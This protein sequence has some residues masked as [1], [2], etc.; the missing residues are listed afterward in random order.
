MATINGLGIDLGALSKFM[1]SAYKD[2]TENSPVCHRVYNLEDAAAERLLAMDPAE[3]TETALAKF[4][5]HPSKEKSTISS[6]PQWWTDLVLKC[7]RERND[8]SSVE[9]LDPSGFDE[10]GFVI[11][12]NG[13]CTH[14]ECPLNVYYQIV[15]ECAS[16]TP[17]TQQ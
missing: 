7:V 9:I 10:K 16:T 17:Q 2:T 4:M 1:G 14:T 8:T 12:P 5:V 11:I 13:C 3:L 15:L 6:D